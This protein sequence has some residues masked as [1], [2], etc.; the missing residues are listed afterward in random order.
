MDCHY[1]LAK[2][3]LN[4]VVA[5]HK[6]FQQWL[7]E[8]CGNKPQMASIDICHMVGKFYLKSIIPFLSLNNQIHLAGIR[9]SQVI[10]AGIRLNLLGLLVQ[11]G[12]HQPFKL[13]PIRQR[14]LP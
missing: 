9:C 3:G 11:L 8:N 10:E 12:N 6:P 13:W 1:V 14:T 4:R 2:T 7:V 5:K